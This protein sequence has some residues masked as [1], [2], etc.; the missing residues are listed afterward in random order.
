MENK[1]IL[2]KIRKN[3]LAVVLFFNIVAWTLLT[4]SDAI[5][6]QKDSGQSIT[7]LLVYA[8]P[9]MMCI[10][11]VICEVKGLV[12]G[13]SAK[14]KVT[15]IIIWFVCG[16]IFSVVI[17][18]SVNNNNWIVKQATGGWEHFLNGIEY[19]IMGVLW[20]IGCTIVFI[21]VYIIEW[22][23]DRIHKKNCKNKC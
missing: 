6:E 7:W 23:I 18:M 21:I 1:R 19:M 20:T 15:N 8:M 2:E 22:I 5:E 16:S 10:L 12:N 17:G 4:I 13:A 11:F 14:G 3:I 9:I